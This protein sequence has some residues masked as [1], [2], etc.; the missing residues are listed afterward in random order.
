MSKLRDIQTNQKDFSAFSFTLKK[1]LE[2]HPDFSATQLSSM[3]A[4]SLGARSYE[5]MPFEAKNDA[6]AAKVEPKARIA[7]GLYIVASQ[8]GECFDLSSEKFV[9]V[10]TA[11]EDQTIAFFTSRKCIMAENHLA[12]SEALIDPDK[13]SQ[14]IHIRR[15]STTR[16]SKLIDFCEDLDLNAIELQSK[17]SEYPYLGLGR[18]FYKDEAGEGNIQLGY[19]GWVASQLEQIIE[20]RTDNY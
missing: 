16:D 5:A 3:I 7:D 11:I 9:K 15:L 14:V 17:Y 18:S 2:A 20:D 10:L 12:S 6:Q 4:Q 8:Y 19:W 1:Q 13:E